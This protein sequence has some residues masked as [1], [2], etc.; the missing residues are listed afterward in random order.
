M[1]QAPRRLRSPSPVVSS[2]RSRVLLAPKTLNKRLTRPVKLASAEALEAAT[3]AL[4][5]AEVESDATTSSDEGPSGPKRRRTLA[6]RPSRKELLVEEFSE[7]AMSFLEHSAVRNGER[8]EKSLAE[9]IR[10]ADEQTPPRRLVADAEVDAAGVDFCNLLFSKGFSANKGEVLLAALM[11]RAPEFGRYGARKLPRWARA[12]RGWR[13]RCPP[14]SRA[15]HAFAVW[16]GIL[17]GFCRRAEW[18]MAV[19]TAWMLGMYM[20]PSEALTIRRGDL[21]KPLVGESSHWQLLLFPETRSDRS[22]VFA[23]NDSIECC[24]SWMPWLENTVETLAVGPPKELVFTFTYSQFL[25][26]WKEVREEIGVAVVPYEARH[27]GASIDAARGHRSRAEIKARGRWAADSSVNR[28][29]KKAR[30]LESF[31][32]LSVAQ[33]EYLLACERQLGDML[34]RGG[35]PAALAPPSTLASAW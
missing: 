18:L 6:G 35:S 22:K 11:H 5:G 24:C 15:P 28:Y 12:L 4:T 27:S 2:S 23:A 7:S 33:Q 8:Y 16:S 34:E 14:R 32:K 1:L 17:W 3:T 30:L 29:E 20:R 21:Q 13:M 25:K 19:Y 26:V 10:W 9:W 31:N